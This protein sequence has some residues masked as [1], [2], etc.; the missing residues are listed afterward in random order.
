LK[1]IIAAIDRLFVMEDWHNFGAYYDRTLLAW[2]KNLED[3]FATTTV[4][5]GFRRVWM[6]Y[7]STCAGAFRVRD[8]TQL[9]Q[10]VLSKHGVRGGY[11][12][13]R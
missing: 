7:L 8:R 12:S 4:A 1:D 2:R 11:V 3:Y 6:Y 5:E 9:W 13:V 10:L